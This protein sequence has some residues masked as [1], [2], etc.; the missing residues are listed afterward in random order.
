MMT[1]KACVGLGFALIAA[2]GCGTDRKDPC[3]GAKSGEACLWAGTGDQGFN[4]GNP[5]AHRLDSELDW[6]TDLTFGPD[7]RAYIVDFNNHQIRRVE[8]DQTIHTLMGTPYEGDGDPNMNNRL[9]VCNPAGAQGTIVAMN[10]PTDA[11]FGPDGLLYI[12][13][14]H[15]N[16]IET[17]NVDTDEVKNFG[18]NTYANSPPGMSAPGD[19]G[20]ACMAGYDQPKTLVFGP[21]GTMYIDDQRNVRV[22]QVDVGT[23]TIHTIAGTGQ[24][25]NLGDGGPAIMAELGFQP[26]ETPQPTGALAIKDGILYIADTTNN[27]IRR[28][29]LTGTDAGIIDCIAGASAQPGYTGDGGQALDAEFNWPVDLEWGPDGRLYLADR[30]NHAIRAIDLTTGI[31]DTVAGG[32]FCD[33]TQGKCPDHAPAKQMPLNEPQGIAFDADGN[34]YIADTFNDRIIKVIK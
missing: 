20:P 11:K 12:A 30:K 15:N 8:K 21:D 6:P 18:G 24:Q 16:K 1:T 23:E 5:T 27:R 7:G 29:H 14:W 9:P 25:G 3:S 10:H 32:T 22:R 4:N 28:V 17:L 34:M 31:V 13:A 26:Q 33:T 2:A 19:G